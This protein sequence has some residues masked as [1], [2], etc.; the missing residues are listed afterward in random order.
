MTPNPSWFM[1]YSDQFGVQDTLRFC[2]AAGLHFAD[3]SRICSWLYSTRK[4][5]LVPLC[6]LYTV[7][8]EIC[9]FLSTR[10]ISL[11][12]SIFLRCFHCSATTNIIWLDGPSAQSCVLCIRSL[13]HFGGITL[14]HCPLWSWI[15]CS[16]RWHRWWHVEGQIMNSAMDAPTHRLSTKMP[17]EGSA[18]LESSE[19]TTTNRWH[20][21]FLF[22]DANMLSVCNWYEGL[23][24]FE[25]AKFL[26]IKVWS[27]SFTCFWCQY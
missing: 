5:C 3:F 4:T 17:D 12:D 2:S 7:V 6:F 24:L 20:F 13:L 15:R 27:R 23:V 8:L 10:Q 18:H 14:L 21:F 16:L 19:Q 25:P 11:S 1:I 22:S 9:T 26:G